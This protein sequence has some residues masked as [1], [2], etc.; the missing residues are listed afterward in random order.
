MTKAIC[1]YC[2]KNVSKLSEQGQELH[3]AVCFDKQMKD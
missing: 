2:R 3:V 1:A